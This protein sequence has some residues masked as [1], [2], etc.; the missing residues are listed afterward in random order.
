MS[1][2]KSKSLSNSID[3]KDAAMDLEVRD[4]DDRIF[5]IWNLQIMMDLNGSETPT[6]F[7]LD[8]FYHPDL[9]DD[10][11]VTTSKTPFFT[12]DAAFPGFNLMFRSMKDRIE[13]FFNIDVFKR[14]ML[15]EGT[16][17]VNREE[18]DK[19]SEKESE[20]IGKMVEY[21]P[22]SREEEDNERENVKTMLRCLFSISNKF[23]YSIAST[24][25]HYIKGKWNP[26]ILY[27]V[28]VLESFNLFGF[29]ER[30]GI[31]K[32]DRGVS[33]LK[34]GGQPK[35]IMNTVWEDDLV[36][37][38]VYREFIKAYYKQLTQSKPTKR[39]VVNNLNVGKHKLDAQLMK[40][41][42][43]SN[44][45]KTIISRI[46]EYVSGTKRSY[47]DLFQ[48]SSKQK[49]SV[50]TLEWN[51]VNMSD[52][53]LVEVLTDVFEDKAPLN[54]KLTTENETIKDDANAKL[55]RVDSFHDINSVVRVLKN[56][57][58]LRVIVSFLYASVSNDTRNFTKDTAI[59]NVAS[60]FE[61]IGDTDYGHDMLKAANEIGLI[62]I[63]IS[64]YEKNT[65]STFQFGDFDKMFKADYLN[66][67][68]DVLV[69]Q[70][71]IDFIQRN[72]IIRVAKEGVYFDGTKEN[73]L[74][75]LMIA[76][77]RKLYPDVLE[78][79]NQLGTSLFNVVRPKRITSNPN[80]YHLLSRVQMGR[81]P[82][83]DDPEQQ[84]Q[85][86]REKTMLV[87]IHNKYFSRFPPNHRNRQETPYMCTGV[88]TVIQANPNAG[89]DKSVEKEM[90]EIYVR[91]TIVDH[92]KYMEDKNAECKISDDFLANEIH[93]LLDVNS[94]ALTN[95]YRDFRLLDGIT[96]SK[97]E[98]GPPT[99]TSASNSRTGG[100]VYNRIRKSRSSRIR[101]KRVTRK[102]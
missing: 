100:S 81:W 39:K 7:N 27:G 71:V 56:K 47:D 99:S 66:L 16:N 34:I 22:I 96:E 89:S 50:D 97:S 21:T 83:T 42:Y 64:E 36:N 17:W 15:L 13:F 70:Q 53:K 85:Y 60:K 38:P 37:H 45:K 86:E 12:R 29:M 101:G 75:K 28:D 52:S 14:I 40:N 2:T 18:L 25:E 84:K 1:R 88:D 65:N 5:Q 49:V 94:T 57:E 33:F 35:I 62:P 20:E 58:C 63:A 32:K 11:P 8:M 9:E 92:A 24:F 51:L 68:I 4:E 26:D 87:F 90:L 79:S 98:T 67:A 44:L 78:T 93:Y 61:Q 69:A 10:K 41:R 95:P 43:L 23:D 19:Q 48:T 76:R 6:P 46:K 73:E 30:F 55:Y 59:R 102:W 74:D 91:F 72:T 31:T 82:E 3:S 80:L 77:I 54:A